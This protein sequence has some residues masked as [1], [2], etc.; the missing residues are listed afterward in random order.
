MSR[1]SQAPCNRDPQGF[2]WQ[3]QRQL[4]TLLL[5]STTSTAAISKE[6]WQPAGSN[7]RFHPCRLK[8]ADFRFPAVFASSP[9]LESVKVKQ[10]TSARF[11]SNERWKIS[12]LA[13][14]QWM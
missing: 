7:R 8:L 10:K 3:E 9:E 5:A 14:F 4:Q 1:H 13:A 11:H 6:D 12:T 2:E